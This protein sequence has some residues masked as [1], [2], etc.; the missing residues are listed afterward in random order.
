M[1]HGPESADRIEKDG[2]LERAR[3]ALE[4]MKEEMDRSKKRIRD[5][6]ITFKP[7]KHKKLRKLNYNVEKEDWGAEM[8]ELEA[9]EEKERVEGR[10]LDSNLTEATINTKGLKQQKIKIWTWLEISALKILKELADKAVEEKDR[11]T[12]ESDIEESLNWILTTTDEDITEDWKTLLPESRA[13]EESTTSAMAPTSITSS[14]PIAAASEELKKKYI[15]K[16]KQRYIIFI[17]KD[18]RIL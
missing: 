13:T 14:A 10:F 6:D 1:D 2:K 5:G 8:K 7:R 15:N 16:K 3:K 17:F 11:Q 12:E 4:R 9:L 18:I